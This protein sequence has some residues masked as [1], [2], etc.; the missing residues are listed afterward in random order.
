[1]TEPKK[2]FVV[3]R[4]NESIYVLKFSPL[5]RESVD[6]WRDY[7]LKYN[8]KFPDPLRALYDYTDCNEMPSP[9]VLS[10]IREVTP[11]LITPK[12][13]RNAYLCP[14][15]SFLVWANVFFGTRVERGGAMSFLDR[16][17]AVSWL[18]EGLTETIEENP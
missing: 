2:S 11:K 12:N 15:Q 3:F 13:T 4:E 8:G 9:Y 1:M 7:L 17:K 6:A 14:N 18:M 16:E 5:N 10:V